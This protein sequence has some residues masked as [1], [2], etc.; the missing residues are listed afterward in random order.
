VSAPGGHYGVED[1]DRSVP[2]DRIPAGAATGSRPA[3]RPDPGRRRDRIPAELHRL[4]HTQAELLA[5]HLG[6]LSPAD[7]A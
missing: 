1:V 2:D 7:R 5:G 4:E 3:P 6:P